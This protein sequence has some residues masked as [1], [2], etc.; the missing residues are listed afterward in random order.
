MPDS[1]DDNDFAAQL[2]YWWQLYP[3]DGLPLVIKEKVFIYEIR[4]SLSI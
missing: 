2:S 3:F 4:D 1:F